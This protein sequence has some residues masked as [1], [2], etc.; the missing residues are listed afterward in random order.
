MDDAAKHIKYSF[1]NL[2]AQNGSVH[3]MDIDL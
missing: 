2:V 3:G 1:D